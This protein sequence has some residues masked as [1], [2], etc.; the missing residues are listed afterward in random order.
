MSVADLGLREYSTSLRRAGIRL[1]KLRKFFLSRGV[2]E[3]ALV[4]ATRLNESNVDTIR[5]EF[6]EAEG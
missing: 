6:I 3:S 2:P 1:E 4:L 5:V